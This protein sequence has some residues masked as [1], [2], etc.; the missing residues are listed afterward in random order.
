M[1]YFRIRISQSNCTTYHID[2]SSAQAAKQ[3]VQEAHAAKDTNMVS[4][5]YR[6]EDISDE[7]T[8]VVRM[9]DDGEIY[10]ADRVN[11]GL[12]DL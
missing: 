5:L 12:K 1:P 11:A 6:V 2:A 9:P 10:R 7:N 3:F 4:G 8:E